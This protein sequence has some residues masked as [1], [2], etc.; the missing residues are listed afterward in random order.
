MKL[1]STIAA[2]CILLTTSY[3]FSEDSYTKQ[4]EA[5]QKKTQEIMDLLYDYPTDPIG[6]ILRSLHAAFDEMIALTKKHNPSQLEQ[7]ELAYTQNRSI[8][9]NALLEDTY[10]LMQEESLARTWLVSDL[11]NEGLYESIIE[12][13]EFSKVILE[14]CEDYEIN[15]YKK[16]LIEHLATLLDHLKQI[17]GKELNTLTSK[18]VLLLDG[19]DQIKAAAAK[20]IEAFDYVPEKD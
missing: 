14:R 15:D 9:L 5:L 19:Y 2:V 17:H 11:E 16:E 4:I 7:F 10:T 8:L 20:I 13:V 18:E 6:D 1:I 12:Y 3:S